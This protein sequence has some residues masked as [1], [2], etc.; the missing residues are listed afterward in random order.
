MKLSINTKLSLRKMTSVVV[1]LLLYYIY[2]N[3]VRKVMIPLSGIVI[4]AIL[5]LTV[6]VSIYQK[7]G[8]IVVK[9]AF[10]KWQCISWVSIAVLILID[11][12]DLLK[13]LIENGMVQL[14]AMIFFFLFAVRYN[15][16]QNTWIKATRVFVMI[17]TL[18]TIIFLY[19]PSAYYRFAAFFFSGNTLSDLLRYY[20]KGWMSGLSTHFSSN[21]MILAIG[22][23]VFFEYTRE[24]KR[25]GSPKKKLYFNYICT[26]LV[27][28]ALILSSKRGPLI[29]AFI[30]ISVTYIFAEGKNVGKRLLLFFVACITLYLLYIVLVNSIPG[31]ATIMNKFNALEESDTGILNGRLR[32]W[33]LAI[34]MFKSSPIWGKGYGSYEIISA[35]NGS[36]TSAHNFYLSA[37]GELGII[38]FGLF[39]MAFLTGVL[40]V[41]KLLKNEWKNGNKN[42]MILCVSLEIQLFVILYCMTATALMY[43]CI[44][45]PYFF[46]CAVPRCPMTKRPAEKIENE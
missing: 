43:Y 45:I 5:L 27:L 24:L 8:S 42:R 31:L 20:N 35:G 33:D 44:L 15:E 3:S 19:V 32:R 17:H 18:A 26:V 7:R 40:S 34:D 46:A 22:L 25:A 21:G 38:G 4:P 13:N 11:N 2:M 36:Q 1:F 12:A 28:Y 14:F 23:I 41:G 29:A 39:C 30:A 37:L 6:A 10:D 16:W 9:N